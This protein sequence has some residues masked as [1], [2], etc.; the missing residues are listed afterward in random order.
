MGCSVHLYDFLFICLFE[1]SILIVYHPV[2]GVAG[3]LL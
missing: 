2:D 1:M 3:V